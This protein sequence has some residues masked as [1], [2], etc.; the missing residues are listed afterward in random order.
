MLVVG[1]YREPVQSRGVVV[2]P[3]DVG[4]V[5][6]TKQDVK[7]TTDTVQRAER[8]GHL[9]ERPGGCLQLLPGS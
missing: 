8:V 3:T 1:P 6:W 4:L 5:K 9:V 7:A 2:M